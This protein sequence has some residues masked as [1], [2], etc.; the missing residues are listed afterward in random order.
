[1][2]Y[3]KIRP[4]IDPKTFSV[5]LVYNFAAG[6]QRKKPPR[7]RSSFLNLGLGRKFML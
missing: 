3:K 7:F 2:N 1:M 5:F 6:I 4:E